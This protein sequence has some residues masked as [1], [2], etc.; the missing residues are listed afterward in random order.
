DVLTGILREGAQ[1]MLAQAI[2]AE[3]AE[4][5]ESHRE[6]R[7]AAGRRQVVRNG[8]LP[9]RTILSGVGPIEVE[10][11]RVLDRR[12]DGEAECFSSRILPPYLR[13]TKSLG[14]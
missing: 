1:R 14:E 4:W 8:R 12:P 9:Q 6:L 2:D 13:K 11:P 3:V 5:I 10:Q 7:D